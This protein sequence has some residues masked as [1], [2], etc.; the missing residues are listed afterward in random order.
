[1][2]KTNQFGCI[3]KILSQAHLFYYIFYLDKI[4]NLKREINLE[5]EIKSC[6]RSER[7]SFY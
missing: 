4:D 6:K 1:L 2:F 3:K 7:Q 5:I